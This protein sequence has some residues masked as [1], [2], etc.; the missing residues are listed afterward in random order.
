MAIMQ[1]ISWHKKMINLINKINP[2]IEILV[3]IPGVKPRTN[4]INTIC[5]YCAEKGVTWE[6]VYDGDTCVGA[7]SSSALN[8]AVEQCLLSI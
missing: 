1:Q 2:K 5:N 6:G 8:N 3:D 4:N 7:A